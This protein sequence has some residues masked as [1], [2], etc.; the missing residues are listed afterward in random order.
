MAA[1]A[2]TNWL[3]RRCGIV[4]VRPKVIMEQIG[5]R[6]VKRNKT[7]FRVQDFANRFMYQLEKIAQVDRRNRA[8]DD[9]GHD[10]ALELQSRASGDV[11]R[12][13]QLGRPAEK[14]DRM[15]ANLNID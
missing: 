12:Q 1:E 15:P 5:C 14:L 13:H 3:R 4:L 8:V 6:I 7:V 9:V 10:L 11:I 2:G